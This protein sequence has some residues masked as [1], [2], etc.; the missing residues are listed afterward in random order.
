MTSVGTKRRGKHHGV[1]AVVLR[2]G[3]GE[4]VAEAVELF[5]VDGVNIKAASH[6]AFHDGA[7]SDFNS[8]GDILWD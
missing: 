2:S 1:S 8:Y 5:G 6:E 4:S 7:A 3:G